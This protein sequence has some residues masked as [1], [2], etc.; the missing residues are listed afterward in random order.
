MKFIKILF[1]IV[2]TLIIVI[3][4]TLGYFGLFPGVSKV[5][6][7]D[8]PRDLGTSYTQT[9]YDSA[10]LKNKI[11]IVVTDSAPDIK[12]SVKLEGAQQIN[13]SWTAEEI[14]AR[15]NMNAGNWEYI[16]IKDVQVRFNP[17]GTV[18]ASGLLIVSRLRGLAEGTKVSP[19]D[20]Q[21]ISKIFDEYKIPRITIP[22]YMKGT[23]S[24]TDNNIDIAVPKLEIGR[25]T[26][27]VG[28]YEKAKVP[29]ENFAKK[30]L[31][32]GGYGSLYI[33]SLDFIGGKM[34]FNGTLPQTITTAKTI[35]G[36]K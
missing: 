25:L 5:F 20:I 31:T 8:K 2:I 28:T 7:S 21:A 9:D 6:G 22:V 27:P 32:G 36:S 12:S 13:N 17:D 3:I 30:Q 19:A 35:L 18:E 23:L 29:F 26:I 11:K 4:L 24:V 14:T 16:P 34:N 10:G 33:K 1:T 15:I